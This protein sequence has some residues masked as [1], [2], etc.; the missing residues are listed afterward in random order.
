M[1]LIEAFNALY[2]AASSEEQDE[3]DKT[4]KYK[5]S[6]DTPILRDYIRELLAEIEEL[7][8]EVICQKD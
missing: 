5:I 3:W 8:R 1:K 2:M 6:N 4:N 7:K